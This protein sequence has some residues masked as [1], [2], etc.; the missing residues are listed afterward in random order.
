MKKVLI[1]IDY[2]S[3]AQK[4]AELGHALGNAMDAQIVLLH[5]IEN[6]AYYASSVYDPIMGFGGFMNLDFSQ[7]DILKLLKNE[8]EAFLQRTKEHLG[9]TNITTLVKEGKI[10]T[11]ILETAIKI[12]A[13]MIVM[14]THSKNWFEHILLGSEA[15]KVLHQS[16]IPVLIIPTK[17]N[18]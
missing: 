4:V 14:G 8:S 18:S 6:P 15:Q 17:E 13:D 11:E 9:S 10:A 3:T 2:F 12:D 1:A 7:P 5:V 16:K